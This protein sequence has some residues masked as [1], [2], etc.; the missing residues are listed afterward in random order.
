MLFFLLTQVFGIF[1]LNHYIIKEVTTTKVG[2][3]TV[4]NTTIDWKSAPFA[5][6]PPKVNETT[7]FIYIFIAL[8]ISTAL[9][10]LLIKLK[11]RALGKSWYII[12][13]IIAM[14]VSLGAFMSTKY[15]IILAVI[16]SFLKVYKRNFYTH[17]FTEP[18]VYSGVA[19]FLAPLFNMYSIIALLILVAIY[20][21]LA[22]NKIKHMVTLAKFQLSNNNFVGLMI[23]KNK[24]QSLTIKKDELNNK[25]KVENKDDSNMAVLGGGDLTFPLIFF[26]VMLKYFVVWKVITAAFVVTF[27]LGLLLVIS[28]KGKFYPAMPFLSAGCIVG[29]LI[30][31]II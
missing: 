22:V 4:T 8:L 11:A 15:A 31:L 9:F 20:D 28:K 3:I 6:K 26:G 19:V 13:I 7:S 14:S 29:Y 24:N 2:N 12:T 5:G 18:L 27:F 21:Y 25:G 10:L 30:A 17:N 1:V 23:P 16:L